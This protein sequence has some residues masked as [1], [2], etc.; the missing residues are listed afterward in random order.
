VRTPDA[1]TPLVRELAR[2]EQVA[3]AAQRAEIDYQNNF[4]AELT[5]LERVRQFAFRRLELV[6]RMAAAGDVA[7]DEQSVRRQSAALIEEIGWH[8]DTER[9]RM[10]LEAWRPVAL[11]VWRELERSR[12]GAG[13][14][15]ETATG[16]ATG[17]GGEGPGGTRA[18]A[19]EAGI[20][21]AFAVFEARYEAEVGT[22]FLALLDREMVETP[23]VEF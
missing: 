6:R 23:V 14:A 7:D 17:R 19:S 8:G 2:L 10:L 1:E 21:E 16:T 9:R 3:I 18:P 5:R 13:K 11:A 12:P 22:P 4:A 20:A 15:S